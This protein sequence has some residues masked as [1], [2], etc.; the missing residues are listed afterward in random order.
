MTA[1]MAAPRERPILFRGEMVRAVLAGRKTQTRRIVRWPEWVTNHAVAASDLSDLPAIGLFVDGR[2]TR[3]FTCPYGQTGGLLWVRETWGI[4]IGPGGWVGDSTICYRADGGQRP[5]FG[6][7]G[8]V[9]MLR[10]R[11]SR[12]RPS[13]HMP[14][15]ASRITLRVTDVRV[16]RLEE[17][18]EADAKAEGVL[19]AI[20]Q[21]HHAAFRDLWRRVHGADA[22]RSNPWLWVISFKRV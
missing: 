22:W 19:P 15:W 1:T 6:T 13:I 11:H 21:T 2:Q 9:G 7:L 20:E 18:T 14:R 3:R 17:I 16:E 5:L 8:T 4:A 12:W 10:S